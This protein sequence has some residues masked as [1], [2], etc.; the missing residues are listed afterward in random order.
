MIIDLMNTVDFKIIVIA[1]MILA[2]MIFWAIDQRALKKAERE[3][4]ELNKERDLFWEEHRWAD[5]DD[6]AR[7]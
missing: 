4:D 7:I 1:I 3:L 2:G 6:C 5:T